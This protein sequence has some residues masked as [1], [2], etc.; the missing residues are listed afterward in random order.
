LDCQDTIITKENFSQYESIVQKSIQNW[1]NDN[2][3]DAKIIG[4]T[5]L[6]SGIINRVLNIAKVIKKID[7]NIRVVI[8]GHHPTIFHKEILINSPEIDYVVLGE[9]EEQF[10]QLLQL[11]SAKTITEK[12]LD[13][14]IAFRSGSEIIVKEKIKYINELG[15]LGTNDFDLIEFPKYH[16][17]DMD[18]FYNPKGHKII[19]AMPIATSR[20]CPFKC[21]FCGM[22]AVMGKKFRSRPNDTV[23]DEIKKL[24]YDYGI[25]YF[26]I[27]DDCSTANK[28]NSM[29][30]FSSIVNSDMEISFE[31]YNGMSIRSLDGEL[32][33]VLVEAGLL[34]ASLAI[35]TGSSHLRNEVIK[36]KLSNEKIYEIYEYFDRKH[37]SIWLNGLFIVGLPEETVE[38]LEAT[39]R[40]LKKMPRIY[41]VFNILIPLPGTEIWEQCLRDN[42]IIPDIKNIWKKS[43]S[44]SPPTLDSADK[45]TGDWCAET[46]NVIENIFLV[47]PYNLDLDQLAYYYK[48]LL[49]I[50]AL[51]WK[52]I[53]IWKETGEFIL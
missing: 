28:K 14:G 21:N 39:I 13:N 49:K 53:K 33:D 16:T 2:K 10:V 35:E 24:Y 17:P 8:G 9:G 3:N 27:I 46:F 12:H 37:P 18:S 42:L 43:L 52:R 7:S 31:F 45:E 23:L 22:N 50:K 41:P 29:D 47:R 40:M 32:I 1:I 19:C 36:K 15:R 5:A 11:Y 26:R 48:E 34:R 4:I 38:T 30:L 44:A 51:S 20:A 6:F 25:R